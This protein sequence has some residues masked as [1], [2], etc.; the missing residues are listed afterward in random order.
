MTLFRFS[1]SLLATVTFAALLLLAVD[2]VRGQSPAQAAL[3]ILSRDGKRRCRRRQQCRTI[4]NWCRSL[5]DLSSTF[6]LTTR[7]ETVSGALAV[8]YKGKTILLTPDQP[9]VS[10]A[11]RL[12]SLPAAPTRN[13]RRVLVPVEFIS[14]ALALIYDARLDLRKPSRLLIVGDWRVPR[15]TMRIDPGDQPRIVV[16]AAPRTESSVSQQN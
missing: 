5:D 16:D 15:V 11:G 3:T 14:R 12:V 2:P 7:D 6:Q 13:G 8:G 1:A 10:I 9:L 4:R